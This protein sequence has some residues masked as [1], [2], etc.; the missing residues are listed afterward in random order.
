MILPVV[1]ANPKRIH[2]IFQKY[3]KGIREEPGTILGTILIE[4]VL[5]CNA[6]P[7]TV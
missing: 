1:I 5:P 7:I 2:H 4:H 6:S 3:T